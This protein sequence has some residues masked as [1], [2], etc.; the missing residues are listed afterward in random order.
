MAALRALSARFCLGLGETP[1]L[2]GVRHFLR[3]VG[4]AMTVGVPR[5]EVSHR[6]D[7]GVVPL[8]VEWRVCAVYVAQSLTRGAHAR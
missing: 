4:I 1:G 2:P 7:R 5:S 3:L 6:A 8:C